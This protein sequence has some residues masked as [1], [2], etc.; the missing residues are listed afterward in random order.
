MSKQKSLSN[1]RA[2]VLFSGGQDSTTALAYALQNFDYIETVGFDYGQRNNVELECREI[3]KAQLRDQFDLWREKLG[4]D[5]LITIESLKQITDSA[6]VQD[7]NEI[8]VGEHGLPTTFVPGRN[9]FF[10]TYAA[11]IGYQND[12]GNLVGG[13]C[14]TDF[15]GYPDCREETLQNLER[16]LS[17]GMDADF[18]IVTPL[19]WKTKAESWALA[20]QLGGEALTNIIRE[21]THTCYKGTRDTLHEWGY[22]CD[23]CPACE[24]RKKGF[25][26]WQAMSA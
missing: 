18:K 7:D 21:H 24:L 4:K 2:L 22:G 19:M 20:Y 12:F 25:I 5:H 26:E 15:S 8:S 13:M 23:D 6:L 3:V 11:V 9:L 10:F 17:L 14:Q 16:T 1:K